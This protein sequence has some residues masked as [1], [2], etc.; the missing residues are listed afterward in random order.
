MK[1]ISIGQWLLMAAALLVFAALKIAM[2]YWYAERDP[3]PQA[4]TDEAC[5]VRRGCKLP[6]GATLRTFGKLHPK[7][8][9]RMRLLNA[10]AA[11]QSVYVEFSMKDMDMGFNRYKLLPP[12][13]DHEH[14]YA[15]TVRLPVCVVARKDYLLD[16]Y[17]DGVGYQIAF[18]S[19]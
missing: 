15:D 19:D 4:V 1:K 14:W 3:A 16:I 17:L 8:P 18:D 10:P 9:F 11:T 6:N 2:V 7:T 13:A 5:D 12:D